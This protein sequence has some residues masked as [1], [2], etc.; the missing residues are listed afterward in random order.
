MFSIIHLREAFSMETRALVYH[1]QAVPEMVPGYPEGPA[2]SFFLLDLKTK[3][4]KEL[5]KDELRAI[6]KYVQ[7]KR[8]RIFV[9]QFLKGDP[10]E[11]AEAAMG[12]NIR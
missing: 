9:W 2:M 12:A 5:T 6:Y 3:A 8:D 10:Y 4:I 1:E 7:Y 11:G